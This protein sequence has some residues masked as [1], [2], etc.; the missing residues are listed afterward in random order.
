[1]PKRPPHFMI[2]GTL[3]TVSHYAHVG[4]EFVRVILFHHAIPVSQWL[5]GWA[6]SPV[7]SISATAVDVSVAILAIRLLLLACRVI[8]AISE[9][10]GAMEN[11]CVDWG[12]RKIVELA[13]WT[14][15]RLQNC[16]PQQELDSDAA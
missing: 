3:A 6:L 15:A 9:S 11:R 14:L 16:P 5:S 13:N 4:S 8:L 1:M 7:E 10:I 2:T 12:R